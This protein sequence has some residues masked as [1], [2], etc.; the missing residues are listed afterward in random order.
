MPSSVPVRVWQ[1][2]PVPR[3]LL[4]PTTVA[5]LGMKVVQWVVRVEVVL[6]VNM[7]SC[8]GGGGGGGGGGV[9]GG[10]GGG[11]GVDNG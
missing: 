8:R 7:V 3:L 5:S 10:G 6:R 4:M 11:G 1:N 2:T 9:G